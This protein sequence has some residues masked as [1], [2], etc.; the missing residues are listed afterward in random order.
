LLNEAL[1]LT[2]LGFETSLK[3][4]PKR[5]MFWLVFLKT[6]DLD[7]NVEGPRQEVGVRGFRNPLVIVMA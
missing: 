2:L 6:V 4:A 1:L 3:T 5:L 7:E